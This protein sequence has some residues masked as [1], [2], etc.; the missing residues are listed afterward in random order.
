[1]WIKNKITAN[2]DILAK[3]KY[4]QRDK[5][6]K[7]S[8]KNEAIRN[9][10][11]IIN[12]WLP[13]RFHLSITKKKFRKIWGKLVIIKKTDDSLKS[14]FIQRKKKESRR[15]IIQTKKQ[16]KYRRKR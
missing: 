11:K 2:F 4:A 7:E 15:E 10:K 13:W 6:G 8:T 9:K 5:V 16:L 14:I 3:R 1:M 12:P